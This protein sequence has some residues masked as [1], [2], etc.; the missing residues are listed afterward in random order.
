MQS[1]SVIWVLPHPPLIMRVWLHSMNKLHNILNNSECASFGPEAVELVS[2]ISISRVTFS[3]CTCF[4]QSSDGSTSASAPQGAWRQC[5]LGDKNLIEHVFAPL[6]NDEPNSPNVHRVRKYLTLANKA[7]KMQLS[8]YLRSFATC[9]LIASAGALVPKRQ[10][11]WTSIR[12]PQDSESTLPTPTYGDTDAVFTVCTEQLINAR[13]KSV[14]DALIDYSSYHLWNTFVVDVEVPPGL[15]TP[16]DVYIG[17]DM[18]LVTSG[19]LPLINTTS[20]EVVTG[21][22]E[23]LPTWRSNVT[24]LGALVTAEHPNIL[25]DEGG[26]VTR[27]VSYE[28]Y[29]KNP[30]IISL[31]A[32]R[33][34]L[35]RLFE[36][37]GEDLKAYVESL[38]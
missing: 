16:E 26:G 11:D 32:T 3:S 2:I 27:Y 30:L 15:K 5:F 14:Y 31:L 18:T 36:K 23:N 20:N 21:L 12:C 33:P 37:Q 9:S 24:I 17:M 25:V 28:T 29:Y 22:D 34:T 38:G 8:V 19:I 1:F 6:H 35:Q 7:A 13:S 4:S 10:T